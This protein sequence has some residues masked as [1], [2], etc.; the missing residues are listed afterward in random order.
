MTAAPATRKRLRP[1]RSEYGPAATATT[2]PGA[3]YA[4]TT[5]PAAPVEMPNSPAI[6]VSTGAMTTLA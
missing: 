4:A 6:C 5:R 2:M 3:P 1:N